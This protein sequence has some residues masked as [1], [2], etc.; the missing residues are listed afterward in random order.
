MKKF[1]LLSLILFSLIKTS[2]A[3]HILGGEMGW[4]CLPTGKYIFHMTVYR[5]CTGI[6]FIYENETIII[7]G[8]PLPKGL[9]GN[10]F[11]KITIKPDSL[12]WNTENNGDISPKCSDL[13]DNG[14]SCANSD[15]GSVQQF[16]Y[17]S[18]P[19]TLAGQ[20]NAAGWRFYWESSCCR[21]VD[22]VNV[23]T[24][25]TTL[26][27][28]G[29]YRVPGSNDKDPCIDSSPQFSA[30]PTA[31]FCRGVEVNYNHNVIDTDLDSLVYSWDRP[32]N[33][34]F[35]SPVL[36]NYKNGFS[37]NNPT[38]DASFDSRNIPS[39][40]DAATGQVKMAVYNG[41]N[42]RRYITV[43]K[44]ESYREGAKIAEVF[45]EIPISV[46]SCPSLPNQK[47]NSQPKAV[48]NGD[49]T[50]AY[51]VNVTAGQLIDIPIEVVDKDY[52]DSSNTK[53][54]VLSLQPEGLLFSRDRKMPTPCQVTYGAGQNLFVEPCAYLEK[55]TPSLDTT[56]NPP[57]YQIKDTSDI[58][59]NFIWQTDCSHLQGKTG[60]P[61]TNEAIFNFIFN[62]QDDACPIPGSI[63]PTL[64]VQL[65][66]PVPLTAPIM[67]GIDVDLKGEI[68]YQWV[69]P[70]DSAFT[71]EKYIV[72][73][74]TTLNGI[75]PPTWNNLNNNLKEFQQEKKNVYFQLFFNVNPLDPTSPRNILNKRW[76]RD[77]YMRMRAVSG[78]TNDV[79]SK[80]SDPVRVMELETTGV[81]DSLNSSNQRVNLEWN[82]P[83][84][85]S[86][87][88][89][90]YFKYEAKTRYYIWQ[91]DSIT[92]ASLSDSSNWY[93]RDS[94]YSTQK[95]ISS[96]V[97]GNYAAFRIEARDT[98]VTW[99][100]GS[101]F[102]S[103]ID[104]L[105]TLTFSTFSIIDTVF[106]NYSKPT[107]QRI[108]PEL[109]N[110]D[111]PAD[112]YQWI[113]C[114]TNSLIANANSRDLTLLDTGK[115]AV[116]TQN[117]SCRDTSNCLE[118]LIALNNSIQKRGKDTLES[119][120]NVANY[121]WF[122]CNTKIIIPGANNQKY[123]ATDTGK[124]AVIVSIFNYA[125][126][127]KCLPVSLNLNDSI[128]LIGKDTLK[129]LDNDASY[130]WY[131][132]GDKTIIPGAKK[133]TYVMTDTGYYAVIVSD[134]GYSDTSRC[135]PYF[136]IG[137][138]KQSFQEGIVVYPNPTNEK[139]SIRLNKNYKNI[140][141]RVIS[142]HGQV[143]QEK[144][145]SEQQLIELNLNGKAGI[146]FIQLTN[147][148]GER[149]NFK[150]VK[151]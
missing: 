140:Q 48:I 82:S 2:K 3:S 124:Y 126:T 74:A 150:V 20:P 103:P 105:D 59:T 77:W 121:Q 4:T 23:T 119:L 33:P 8:T 22:I 92:L 73:E 26:L 144:L 69:P 65:R 109:L 49:T 86:A 60:L 41:I 128:V 37:P 57:R 19:I 132:C 89:Y 125:D 6:P 12:R 36:L 39:T 88:T 75:D 83:K 113:D 96:N 17:R 139:L 53:E 43:S 81:D 118:V 149:A 122:N 78:C 14:Y 10:A 54:Q 127:S 97:C 99:K 84:A 46:L 135:Y 38:P 40:I 104:S 72:E 50:L 70:V 90:D 151:Q 114:N 79:E 102:D 107:V 112:S 68:T 56:L 108:G 18:D 100:Q 9:A 58:R 21:P 131:N 146:Y 91:S 71:F 45:R 7:E 129:S 67:K 94:T 61:G 137:L 117:A 11:D 76:N 138:P 115:Y 101:N 5:D 42:T 62:I 134:F 27:R 142:I 80:N 147:Q 30:Y 116:I 44:V 130:Q 64:T 28:A 66:D 34:P 25:G 51:T 15:R 93:L 136:P 120:E 24:T 98:V 52:W 29:M 47:V 55:L 110:T 123:I 141:L 145:V 63:A 16:F 106:L 95:E 1:L 13:Y 143:V 133:Q 148:A 31:I 32:I 111:Y 35:S 87:E 85:D